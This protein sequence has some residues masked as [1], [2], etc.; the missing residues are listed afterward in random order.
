[1]VLVVH[2][3]DAGMHISVIDGVPW[4]PSWKNNTLVYVENV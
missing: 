2:D 3:K 4:R 1:M